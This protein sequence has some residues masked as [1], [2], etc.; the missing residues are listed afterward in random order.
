[1]KLDDVRALESRHIMPTY[2]RQP[3]VFVRGNGARLYDADGS[4]TGSQ[5]TE[6]SP[7]PWIPK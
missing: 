6:L 5:V 1:M 4:S 3:V 2:K 7:M